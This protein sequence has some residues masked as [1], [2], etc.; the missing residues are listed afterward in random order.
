MIYV[1]YGTMHR[2]RNI[3]KGK[4]RYAVIAIGGDVKK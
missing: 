2:V 3:G 4:A 1:A